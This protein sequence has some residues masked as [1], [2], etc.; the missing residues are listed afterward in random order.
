LRCVWQLYKK[1]SIPI[2]GIGGIT[3]LDDILKYYYVG[4]SAVQVGTA[5][6]VDPASPAKLIKELE[7]H[8][9]KEGIRNLSEIIGIAHE[10]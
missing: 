3:T 6:F 5:L 4:A 8:M 2:I 9:E 7:E 1:L 10:E